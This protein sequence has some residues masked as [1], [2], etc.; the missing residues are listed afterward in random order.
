[1]FWL[2]EVLS[3]N[4]SDPPEVE[5]GWSWTLNMGKERRPGS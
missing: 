1:M 2:E 4:R 3:K 5:S